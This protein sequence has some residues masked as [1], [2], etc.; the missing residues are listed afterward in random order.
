MKIVKASTAKRNSMLSPRYKT[1]GVDP[2]THF[3]EIEDSDN[4]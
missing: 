3:C 1:L 2:D 4:T